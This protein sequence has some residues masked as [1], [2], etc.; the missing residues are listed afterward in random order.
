MPSNY[1]ILKRLDDLEAKVATFSSTNEIDLKIATITDS[2]GTL[3]SE[4][5]TIKTKVAVYEFPE[6]HQYILSQNELDFIQRGM[7]DISKLVVEL[8]DLRDSLVRLKQT[9]L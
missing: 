1:S 5:E 2:V 6:D 7:A 8:E 9:S 4:I 3:I